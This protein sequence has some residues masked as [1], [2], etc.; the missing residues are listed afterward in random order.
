MKPLNKELEEYI[1]NEIVPAIKERLIRDIAAPSF[2]ERLVGEDNVI[3]P[4]KPGG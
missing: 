4:I 1:F 2:L 3:V